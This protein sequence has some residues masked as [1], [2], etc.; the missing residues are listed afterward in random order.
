MAIITPRILRISTFLMRQTLQ[1]VPI[2]G[3]HG[4]K[5]LMM[6]VSIREIMVMLMVMETDEGLMNVE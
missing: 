6:V 3:A 2:H 1:A 5:H 4:K